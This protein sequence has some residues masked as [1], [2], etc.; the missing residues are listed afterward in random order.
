MAQARE[1]GQEGS[2]LE[3][4]RWRRRQDGKSGGEKDVLSELCPELYGIHFLLLFSH[5][6]VSNCLQPHEP[7]HTRPPRP[8][9]TP[10][11]YPNSRPLS[12]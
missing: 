5:S 2:G 11:V 7:Q 12:W 9:P 3:G 6:V 10:G 8:S 1:G 4:Q